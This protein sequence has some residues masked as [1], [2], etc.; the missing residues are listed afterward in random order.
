MAETTS[1]PTNL[2]LIVAA[3]R[4]Q[5]AGD[6]LPKQYR[7]LPDRPNTALVT[8]SLAAFLH[9]D[10]IDFV[11]VVIH[12]NDIGLYQASVRDFVDNPKL[13]PPIIGGATRQQSVLLGLEG[14]AAQF[15]DT[16]PKQVLVHDAARPYISDALISRCLLA[17]G[18]AAGAVP[19][20]PVTD[21]LKRGDNGKIAETVSRDGLWQAQTPQAFTF[22]ALLDAHRRAPQ[23]LT[24]D[25]AVAEIAGLPIALVAGEAQNVKLTHEED[26]MPPALQ[27]QPRTGFGYDVHRFADAPSNSHIRLGGI[28]IAHTH[29]LVGH[30]DADVA[31]HAV[32]DALLGALAQGDI[33][34]HFPPS[35]DAHKDR[36]SA[37]FLTHALSLADEAG[38]RLTHIDVTLICQA[39]KIEPHR[40]AMRQRLSELLR[41]PVAAI[42]VKATTTEGLGF[43]GRG[44]GLAAQAVA[45]VLMP[46][47]E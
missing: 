47:A 28:D 36:D 8:A 43:T 32:T 45:T 6:G 29:Q 37:D 18:S 17:L 1:H 39:P 27:V 15:A 2:A 5:R 31:L 3:G 44:E 10:A 9:H 12:Q 26:F 33:G 35:D 4:G 19:A 21:T 13:L 7:A 46:V 11:A 40:E 20:L 38:A 14:L 23:G 25:A 42:S 30:S 16:P 22:A 41:L 24:D 34:S